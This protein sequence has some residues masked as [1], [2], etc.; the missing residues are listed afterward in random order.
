M[1][2]CKHCG[3]LSAAAEEQGGL[4][5]ACLHLVLEAH[6]AGYRE[7]LHDAAAECKKYAHSG[8]NV[9]RRQVSYACERRIMALLNP[10]NGGVEPRRRTPLADT[11]GSTPNNLKG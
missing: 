9:Y 10:P 7:G 1:T 5:N 6:K 8:V 3:E 11:T 4:C 2:R